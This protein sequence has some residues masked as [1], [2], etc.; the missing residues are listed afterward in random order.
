MA[1]KEYSEATK[2]A[3]M[4]ALHDAGTI[5]GTLDIMQRNILHESQ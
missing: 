2:A 3:V 5:A 1:R 4:A